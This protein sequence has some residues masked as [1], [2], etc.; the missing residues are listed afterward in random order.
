MSSQ[1]CVILFLGGDCLI[2]CCLPP[3]GGGGAPGLPPV[4]VF[5][6]W[7]EVCLPGGSASS[8]MWGLPPRGVCPST[9]SGQTRHPLAIDSGQTHSSS[10][11]IRSIGDRYTSYWNAFFFANLFSGFIKF[12][13]IN[14]VISG[15]LYF[16]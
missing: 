9:P 10:Q 6:S 11:T 1:A 2:A 7:G 5:A 13:H 15:K 3:G 8:G 16:H 14:S 12:N 4:G